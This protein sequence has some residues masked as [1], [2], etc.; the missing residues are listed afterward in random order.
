MTLES[1]LQLHELSKK[2]F[3]AWIGKTLGSFLMYQI[4]VQIVLPVILLQEFN[5]EVQMKKK[6]ALF[7]PLSKDMSEVCQVMQLKY[8]IVVCGCFSDRF[9]GFFWKAA[10]IGTT[11]NHFSF[12]CRSSRNI[13]FLHMM[14]NFIPQLWPNKFLLDQLC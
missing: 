14:P 3:L 9:R 6:F 13:L 12:I 1:H 7:S 5:F 10:R 8:F 4:K 2:G 11:V